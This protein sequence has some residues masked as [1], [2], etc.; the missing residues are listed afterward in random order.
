MCEAG[1]IQ[2][3][4]QDGTNPPKLPTRKLASN[5]FAR[6]EVNETSHVA[7]GFTIATLPEIPTKVV[8]K[9]LV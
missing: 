1:R 6:S 5:E 2:D 8:T 9:T 4:R 3:V 7:Y